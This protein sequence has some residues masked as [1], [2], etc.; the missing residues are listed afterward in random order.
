MSYQPAKLSHSSA[1]LLQGL[2]QS[3]FP[4]QLHIA[5]SVAKHQG[6]RVETEVAHQGA[7]KILFIDIVAIADNGTRLVIEC[8]RSQKEIYSGPQISDQAIS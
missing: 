4:F 8:K 2:Q 6:Y 5:E 1:T 7:G 3:G